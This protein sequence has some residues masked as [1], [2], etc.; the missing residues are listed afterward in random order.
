MSFITL[1]QE[2][3]KTMESMLEGYRERL[4]KLDEMLDFKIEE[5]D[6]PIARLYMS[7]NG[8]TLKLNY[9]SCCLQGEELDRFLAY[10]ETVRSE[11]EFIKTQITEPK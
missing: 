6:Q 7:I 10:I 3:E 8:I 11:V 2:L 5:Q 9:N 4:I 1:K